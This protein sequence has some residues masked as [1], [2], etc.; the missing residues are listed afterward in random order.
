[1]N[2]Y[3]ERDYKYKHINDAGSKARL[4][5]E[6][7]LDGLGFL[8]AG[9]WHKTI[10][11]N[12]LLHFLLT[13]AIVVRAL[14]RV[15]R[16]DI[17]VLQYPTK[18]YD[19]ICRVVHLRRARVITFVHDLGC[20]RRKRHSVETEIYR[21]NLSDALIGCNPVVCKWLFDNGFVGYNKE[22]I[23]EPLHV[24]DFLSASMS[25]DRKKTWPLHRIA[26]AGQLSRQKNSFLYDWGQ[27]IEGYAVNV[28]GKGFSKSE[29]MVAEKFDTKGFMPANELICS[30]E[31]DF[32]LVWDGDSVDGCCGDWGEYLVVNTPHKVSLYIR[33][34]LPIIIWRKAAMSGFVEEQGIGICIDSLRDISA[35]YSNLTQDEYNRMYDNVQ[36]VSQMVSNGHFFSK[37]LSEVMYRLQHGQGTAGNRY[38]E[39]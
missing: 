1:M 33:C 37:A 9:G 16:E 28:Y 17:L 18:Y 10:T 31:G 30:S 23:I 6:Q 19:T 13:L 4:D 8:S 25:P 27:Y 34:G 29:A 22:G 3:L 35:I 26:Y 5:I 24:F 14:M 2:Y 38:V 36:R 12:R 11:K 21:L 20:F 39:T 15:K 32:G 7:I